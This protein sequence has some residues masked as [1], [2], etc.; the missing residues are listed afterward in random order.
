MTKLTDELCAEVRRQC[1]DARHFKSLWLRVNDELERVKD[2][3]ET[4]VHTNRIDELQRDNERMQAQIERLTSPLGE[5]LVKASAATAQLDK[6]ARQDCFA[7][8]GTNKC[9]TMN[10]GP[11]LCD[12]RTR[13]EAM[14][15]CDDCGK[16]CDFCRQAALA[17][18]THAT[19]LDAIRWRHVRDNIRDLHAAVFNGATP[20]MYKGKRL[21]TAS[22]IDALIDATIARSN[23]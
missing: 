14:Q 20:L 6:G 16:G 9:C 17:L 12:K 18:Q 2:E 1:D 4:W 10:C 15:D 5:A 3:L 7:C 13:A 23:A 19:Q 22:E 8:H 11:S 21:P